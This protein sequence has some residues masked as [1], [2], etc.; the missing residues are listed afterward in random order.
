MLSSIQ[1]NAVDYY[2]A[3]NI[4]ILKVC[5]NTGKLGSIAYLMKMKGTSLKE[6][7][8]ISNEQSPATFKAALKGYNANDA[9]SAYLHSKAICMDSYYQN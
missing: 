2:E 8:A 7:K 9:N 4:E 6:F 3:A 1:A 5:E